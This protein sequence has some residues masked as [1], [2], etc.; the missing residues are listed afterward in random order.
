MLVT[1]GSFR[2]SE[3]TTDMVSLQYGLHYQRI[4]CKNDSTVQ[5]EQ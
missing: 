2:H 1:A 4:A 3:G 5:R